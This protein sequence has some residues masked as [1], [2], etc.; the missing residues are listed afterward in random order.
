MMRVHTVTFNPAIDQTVTLDHLVRGEVHRARAVRQNAGGKGVNVASCLADWAVPAIAH[1]LLGSDNAAPFDALFAR[2]AIDDRCIRIT[3]STR[4][5]LKLVDANATTDINFDG[6]TVDDG[7]VER[8]IEALCAAVRS[9][10][11]VALSGSLPPGCPCDIYAQLVGRLRALGA[12]VLLDTSG[13]PLKCALDADVLP[14]IIKPNRDE[15][16]GWLGRP[17]EHRDALTGA[18]EALLQRGVDLAVVSM[19][20]EGALFLSADGALHAR[21]ALD[22]VTSTVGAG[23]AMVAGICAAMVEQAG[24]ERLARLAT[25]FAAGKLGMA[26]P[27]LPAR[28]AVEALAAETDVTALTVA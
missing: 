8:V 19:G 6:I 16:A 25:A 26:G 12:T 21:L 22:G 10:D 27:N 17:V 7:C 18:M 2:K 13:L 3:G 23:D 24:L 20:A 9:G 5:N 4:V 11:L 14:N 28:A 1:G 15:L